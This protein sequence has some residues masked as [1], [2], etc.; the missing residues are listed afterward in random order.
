[1]RVA[2]ESATLGKSPP[3]PSFEAGVDGGQRLAKGGVRRGPATRLEIEVREP[4]VK[5][6]VTVAQLQRWASGA[7]KSL[8]TLS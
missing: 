7:T 8:T 4:A 1:M 6:A 5:H 2:P 3:N